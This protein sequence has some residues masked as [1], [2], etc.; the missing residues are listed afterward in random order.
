MSE[1][2]MKKCLICGFDKKV[3]NH[4]IIKVN[5]F[6]SDSEDNLVFLCPNHHWI[7]DFGYGEDRK[8][9]LNIIKDKTGK[10]GS[11]LPKD[12]RCRIDNLAFIAIEED[13]SYFD[14]QFIIKEEEK[15]MWRN[16]Q[17]YRIMK[18]LLLSR[19]QTDMLKREIKRV[20]ILLLIK[21]LKEELKKCQKQA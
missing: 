7:A 19:K 12:K 21:L 15:E 13:L 10:S 5:D 3:D 20:E 2:N 4:H 1:I 14:T 18:N 6:G 17:N 8:L 16:S 9:L 11:L